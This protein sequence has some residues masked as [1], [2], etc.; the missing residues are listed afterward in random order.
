MTADREEGPEIGKRIAR[1]VSWS[2]AGQLGTEVL[3]IV[4][5]FVL[6]RHMTP[7]EFGLVGMVTVLANY[8]NVV[9]NFG[10]GS[11]L[12]QQKE[13]TEEDQST[14]FW[15]NLV[16]GVGLTVLFAAS[17]PAI[18]WFYDSPEIE[19]IS[20][21]MSTN[22]T[23][24]ALAFVQRKR[25]E[26][27]LLFER[28]AVV[29][30]AGSVLS[31]VLAVLGAVLGFGV[32]AL[33][34][35]TLVRS[36]VVTIGTWIAN[37]WIPSL[38]F[39]VGSLRR[40]WSFALNVF[41][42]ETVTYVGNNIDRLLVGQFLGAHALGLYEQASR[43]VLMPVANV[44]LVL[45]RVLM[46]AFSRIQDQPERIAVLYQKGTRIAMFLAAPALVGLAVAGRPFVALA[47]G[48]GWEE[49]PDVLAITAF[50]GL[51][52]TQLAL[53]ASIFR[54]LGRADVEFRLG[55][56]RRG[57]SLPFLGIGLLGD[58]MTTAI[59]R[60]V[61]SVISY[62]MMLYALST[63]VPLTVGQQLTNLRSVA[64]C[65]TVMYAVVWAVDRAIP[66]SWPAAVCLGVDAGVGAFAYLGMAMA[67]REPS[68]TEALALVRT[69]WRGRRSG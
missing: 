47:Y 11:A 44:S 2:A 43:L 28:V 67:L 3:R 14:V 36:T 17:A 59:G 27:D 12:V 58:V 5:G 23:I 35:W 38:L 42:S 31:A 30:M 34:A 65:T 15:L 33:V 18:A 57:G 41:A 56:A 39:D 54:S 66:G 8:A 69:R 10:F 64:V 61:G 50:T 51:A 68:L 53:Q 21:V 1:G 20:L 45:A 37:R 22:F 9:L 40:M 7:A 19:P 16:M 25:L 55:L 60:F 26:R 4:T 46:P 63:V 62:V 6:A 32:W 29:E 49:L 48:S 52:A 13:I 24:S